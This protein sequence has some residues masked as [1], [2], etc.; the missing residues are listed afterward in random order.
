MTR[1]RN[2]K[3]SKK[4]AGD[5]VKGR[6]NT[7]LFQY[8]DDPDIIDNVNVIVKMKKVKS[9]L[10]LMREIFGGALAEFKAKLLAEA[11]RVA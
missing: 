6:V 8:K 3:T 5:D 11:E 10:P 4:S 2:K 9:A 7:V 1:K